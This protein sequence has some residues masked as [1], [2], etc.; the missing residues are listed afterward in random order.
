[1]LCTELQGKLCSHFTEVGVVKYFVISQYQGIANC[2]CARRTKTNEFWRIWA[3]PN[4][5]GE[6]GETGQKPG[7]FRQKLAKLGE[8]G[9]KTG[10]KRANKT[11]PWQNRA[12]P[13]VLPNFG[14]GIATPWSLYTKKTQ[15]LHS[16]E[17]I[18]VCARVFFVHLV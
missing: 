6:P 18:I 11:E 10:I 13:K 7:I 8:T 2:A 5:T 9:P 16:F 15:F 17:A 3:K 1:M 14:F 4:E 12:K